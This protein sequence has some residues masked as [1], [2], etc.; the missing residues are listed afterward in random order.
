[1]EIRTQYPIVREIGREDDPVVSFEPSANR[2][3]VTGVMAAGN[4]CTVATLQSTT[5]QADGIELHG[6]I[7]RKPTGDLL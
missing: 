3:E 5:L 4:P 6:T 2:V 7:G 1:M